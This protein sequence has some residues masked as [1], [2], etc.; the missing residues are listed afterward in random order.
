[1]PERMRERNYQNPRLPVKKKKKKK[2]KKNIRSRGIVR[3]EEANNP[4]NYEIEKNI[5]LGKSI[6]IKN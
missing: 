4:N 1:M 6:N 2:K 3:N 5:E